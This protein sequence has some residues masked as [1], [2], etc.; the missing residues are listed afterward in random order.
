MVT[1][2]RSGG[3]SAVL[4]ESGGPPLS[5][6][7]LAQHDREPGFFLAHELRV[8]CGSLDRSSASTYTL[9]PMRGAWR[10]LRDVSPELISHTVRRIERSFPG[11]R[12][13]DRSTGDIHA[14]VDAFLS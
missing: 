4:D 1:E 7:H 11:W 2:V 14:D 9:Q 3:R 5:V 8:L 10:C 13:T 6:L 12:L